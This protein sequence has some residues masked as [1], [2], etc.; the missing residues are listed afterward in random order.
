[1]VP[2]ADVG[3]DTACWPTRPRRR[4]DGKRPTRVDNLS[5]QAAL[6]PGDEYVV[7]TSS[8]APRP[9]VV[10]RV[11]VGDVDGGDAGFG[12]VVLTINKLQR[13]SRA[14]AKLQLKPRYPK[15]EINRGYG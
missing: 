13:R 10:R 2:L 1:D 8:E 5:E 4:A 6:L 12:D 7:R 14:S 11:H 15:S 9:V 3:L